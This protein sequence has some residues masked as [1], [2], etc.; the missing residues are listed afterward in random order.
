MLCAVS[1][2]EVIHPPDFNLKPLPIAQTQT[3][4]PGTEMT[5]AELT[6][7]ARARNFYLSSVAAVCVQQRQAAQMSEAGGEARP[8]T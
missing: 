7:A 6:E 2:D 3:D 1:L 8:T 4:F 5:D